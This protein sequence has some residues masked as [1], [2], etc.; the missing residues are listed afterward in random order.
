MLEL[1]D[2]VQGMDRALELMYYDKA[3]KD[4]LDSIRNHISQTQLF[5]SAISEM[6]IQFHQSIEEVKST[7]EKEKTS[8][9]EAFQYVMNENSQKCDVK[10]F[11]GLKI[12]VESLESALTTL[13]LENKIL[14]DQIGQHLLRSNINHFEEDLSE[15][16]IKISRLETFNRELRS[17][18]DYFISLLQNMNVPQLTDADPSSS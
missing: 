17:K 14:K 15:Q 10:E 2:K 12:K 8:L 6:K 5:Q 9:R 13:S 7:L 1:K 4:E 11:K 3:G 16:S 18:V